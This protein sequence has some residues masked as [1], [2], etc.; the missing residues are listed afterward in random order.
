MGKCAFQGKP[1]GFYRKRVPAA[2]G[3]VYKGP[4]VGVVP[5]I[6]WQKGQC[7]SSSKM[8]YGSGTWGGMGS[9]TFISVG[10]LFQCHCPLSQVWKIHA[11]SNGRKQEDQAGGERCWAQ[12]SLP[13][14]GVW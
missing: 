12:E 7:S 4:R 9:G 14:P 13:S 5:S 1:L 2:R 8:E 6:C 10:P 3:G 11:K